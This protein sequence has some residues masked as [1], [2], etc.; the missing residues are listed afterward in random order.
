M[1]TSA[2]IRKQ[3]KDIQG[4]TIEIKPQPKGRARISKHGGVFTPAKT[5]AYETA[6]KIF[7]KGAMKGKRLLTG[8]LRLEVHFKFKTSKRGDYWHSKRPDLDNLIKALTDAMNGIVFKDDSEIS[9]ILSSKAYSDMD[10]I[11]AFVQEI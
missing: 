3:E 2:L 4:F 8:P 11:E 7:L 6:L 5:R 10:L 9:V 1:G